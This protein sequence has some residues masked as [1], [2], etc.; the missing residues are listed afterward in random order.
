MSTYKV[1]KVR[2][3][4]YNDGDGSVNIVCDED[5]AKNARIIQNNCVLNDEQIVKIYE[6]LQKN[7]DISSTYV[8][9]KWTAQYEGPDN[10]FSV[11]FRDKDG[12]ASC[13]KLSDLPKA[14]NADL[15]EALSAKP[16]VNN[17]KGHFPHGESR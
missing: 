4:Y 1:T 15:M 9:K 17:I 3:G 5:P 16:K 10:E 8:C 12:K 2:P 6:H 11:N 7:P 13:V 14:E